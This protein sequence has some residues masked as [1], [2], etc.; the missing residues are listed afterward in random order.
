MVMR[1]VFMFRD[2]KHQ[3]VPVEFEWVKGL[4]NHL[5]VQRYLNLHESIKEIYPDV[6]LLEVSTKSLNP[7]GKSLSP[8]ILKT[9]N[10]I[11]VEA[12]YQGSKIYEYGGPFQELYQRSS[13]EAKNHAKG[14]DL[15]D[16]IGFQLGRL[17]FDTKPTRAFYTWLYITV[18]MQ[19]LDLADN[20]MEYNAFT[21][22][23]YNPKTMNVCQAYA[24][25]VYYTLRQGNILDL[26]MESYPNFCKVIYGM[27]VEEPYRV[28]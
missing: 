21:D 4:D 28:I 24:C 27:K 16:V 3:E 12:L 1:P 17:I 9:H 7:V 13:L 23:H 11:T 15:G 14:K 5:I 20:L 2:N 19:N 22:I 8:F 10:G 18:L 26:A 25:S 6:N